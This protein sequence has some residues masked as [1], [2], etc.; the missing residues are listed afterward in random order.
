MRDFNFYAP[1]EVVFGENSE[2]HEDSRVPR[3]QQS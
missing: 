1:T 3:A 2:E